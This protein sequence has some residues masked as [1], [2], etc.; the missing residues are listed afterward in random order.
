MMMMMM[1]MMMMMMMI[2][3]MMV[4]LCSSPFRLEMKGFKSNESVGYQTIR[5]QSVRPDE[6]GGVDEPLICCKKRHFCQSVGTKIAPINNCASGDAEN[7]NKQTK[8]AR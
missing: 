8:L 6:L 2:M 1:I 4:Q 5:Q 7:N 3:V